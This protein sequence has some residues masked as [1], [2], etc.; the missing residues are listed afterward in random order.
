MVRNLLVFVFTFEGFG[1]T[2]FICLILCSGIVKWD[3]ICVAFAYYVDSMLVSS[4]GWWFNFYSRFDMPAWA[5]VNC[6]GP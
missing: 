6:I 4:I 1:R 5:L 3:V 2:F